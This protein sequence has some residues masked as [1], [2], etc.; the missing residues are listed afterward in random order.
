MRVVN[1]LGNHYPVRSPHTSH[2]AHE[3]LKR[4]SAAWFLD[5][6]QAIVALVGVTAR[7]ECVLADKGQQQSAYN[8][9]VHWPGLSAHAARTHVDARR[10]RCRSGF[11]TWSL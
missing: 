10:G 8:A 1:I 2:F 6:G 11:R 5:V 3:L 9:M 4:Q 7:P